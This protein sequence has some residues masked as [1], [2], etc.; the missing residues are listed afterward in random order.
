MK[1]AR[2][3]A[4]FLLCAFMLSCSVDQALSD[5]DVVIQIAANLGVAVGNVSP[6]D[7]A[8]VQTFTT[9]A[10]QGVAAVQA[11]YDTYEKSGATTDLTK[12]QAAIGAVQVNLSQEFAAAHISDPGTQAKITAWAQ[13]IAAS[14]AALSAALPQLTM[15]AGALLNEPTPHVKGSFTQAIPTPEV[16]K[17]RWDSEIC[18][19]DTKCAKRVKVHHYHGFL[20]KIANVFTK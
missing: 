11:A 20:S 10:T 4:I 6:A 3:C 2:T 13:L 15:Q 18:L 16:L 9:I 1:K 7:A 14:L 5:V 8:I 19:G 17:S 12:L